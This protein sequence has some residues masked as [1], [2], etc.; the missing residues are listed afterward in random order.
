MVHDPERD[1]LRGKIPDAAPEPTTAEAADT[2][3][4]STTLSPGA[5]P[6]TGHYGA[7]YGDPTRVDPQ[8][9]DPADLAACDAEYER[10]RSAHIQRLDE[11]YAAW[12]ET[13]AIKF[14]ED[15]DAWRH[16]RRELVIEQSAAGLPL[17]AATDDAPERVKA[18]LLFERS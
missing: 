12:R 13:G 1:L 11:D 5:Q 16:A 10:W 6:A 18:S 15:F 17:V 14:P 4:G 9:A 8:R 7:G 2:P 3:L